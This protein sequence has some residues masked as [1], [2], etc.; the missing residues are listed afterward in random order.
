MLASH[1]E[2]ERCDPV[3]NIGFLGASLVVEA[4]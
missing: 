2:P 1:V 3:I 4:S